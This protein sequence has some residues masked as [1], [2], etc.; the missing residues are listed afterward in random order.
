MNSADIPSEDVG[1]V[2]QSRNVSWKR[3]LLLNVAITI[4]NIPGMGMLCCM[5]FM[6]NLLC[7]LY[8]LTGSMCGHVTLPSGFKAQFSYV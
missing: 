1:A 4:H 3:I 2:A 6:H 8:H 7:L 5:L